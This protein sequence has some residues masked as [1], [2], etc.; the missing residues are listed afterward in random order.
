[1]TPQQAKRIR[2]GTKVTWESSGEK[3]EVTEKGQ[4]GIR[5]MWD[6]GTNA[7]YLYTQTEHGLLHVQTTD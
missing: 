3:G 5:V 2:I 4:A 7:V 1:M 6:D